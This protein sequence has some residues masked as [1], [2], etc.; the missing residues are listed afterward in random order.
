MVGMK[1]E[2]SGR[3]ETRT[4]YGLLHNVGQ[5]GAGGGGCDDC[6]VF[7]AKWLRLR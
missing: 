3:G 2:G 5:V 4:V 1:G 6:G 7:Q